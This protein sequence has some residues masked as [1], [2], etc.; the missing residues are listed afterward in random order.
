MCEPRK[1]MCGG[2]NN[3]QIKSN[4]ISERHDNWSLKRKRWIIPRRD[5][6]SND[7]DAGYI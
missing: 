3:D 5:K 7:F 4:N 6:T 1:K 2:A